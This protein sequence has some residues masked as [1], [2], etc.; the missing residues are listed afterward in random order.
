MSIFLVGRLKVF[1]GDSS[2]VVD[3]PKLITVLDGKEGL[4]FPLGPN[5]MYV[6]T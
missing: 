4:E 5:R 6:F 3:L 1:A 2:H